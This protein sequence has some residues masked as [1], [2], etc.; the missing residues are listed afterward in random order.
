[1]LES[2]KTSINFF[3]VVIV[4]VVSAGIVLRVNG[5]FS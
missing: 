1:M 3:V 5:I 4:A 2:N